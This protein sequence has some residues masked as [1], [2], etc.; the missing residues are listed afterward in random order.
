MLENVQFIVKT[1][2]WNKSNQLTDVAQGFLG[3]FDEFNNRW[4]LF[5]FDKVLMK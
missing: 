5:R 3:F 2:E 4:R 1:F